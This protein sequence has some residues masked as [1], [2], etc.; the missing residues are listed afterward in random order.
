MVPGTIL[1]PIGLFI[2]GWTAEAHTHWIG[3]DIV[4]RPA[5]GYLSD[6][7]LMHKTTGYRPRLC[8]LHIEFPKHPDLRYRRFH[9]TRSI[10][11]CSSHIS[12]VVCRLWFPSLRAGNVSSAGLWKGRFDPRLCGNSD[13]VSSVRCSLQSTSSIMV[14]I[15]CSSADPGCFGNTVRGYGRPVGMLSHEKDSLSDVLPMSPFV[16]FSTLLHVFCAFSRVFFPSFF[17]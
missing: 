7:V 16:W 9:A 6:Q 4:C 5:C 15:F 8:R 2:S 13:W 14:L 12:A 1:L 11:P 3:P 10:R 17:H